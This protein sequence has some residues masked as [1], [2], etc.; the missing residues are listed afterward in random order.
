MNESCYR[1]TLVFWK[2]YRGHEYFELFLHKY[3][4]QHTDFRIVSE[5]TPVILQREQ[6]TFHSTR[7]KGEPSSA[8]GKGEMFK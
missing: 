6:S 4:I 7:L 3:Q 2:I 8:N 5:Y 1:M